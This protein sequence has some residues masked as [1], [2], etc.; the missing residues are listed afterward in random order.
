MLDAIFGTSGQGIWLFMLAIL[1]VGVLAFLLKKLWVRLTCPVRRARVQVLSIEDKNNHLARRVTSFPGSGRPNTG[2]MA[3]T[4]VEE[5]DIVCSLL[6]RGERKIQLKAPKLLDGG[7]PKEG[8]LGV[9]TYQ[10]G[11]VLSFQKAS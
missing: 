3:R 11:R 5:L 2:N 9:I 4:M 10:A 7:L 6:D 8:D 1:V